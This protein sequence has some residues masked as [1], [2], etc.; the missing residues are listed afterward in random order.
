MFY[1]AKGTIGNDQRSLLMQLG[2]GGAVRPSARPGQS[3][4]RGPGGRSSRK[5]LKFCILRYLDEA[6]NHPV[7]TCTEYKVRRKTHQVQEPVQKGKFAQHVF[8]T[9]GKLKL[10]IDLQISFHAHGS[11]PKRINQRSFLGQLHEIDKKT[12]TKPKRL[13][14]ILVTF[15]LLTISVSY[16][17][18]HH[19]KFLAL[20]GNQLD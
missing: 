9:L 10:Q 17:R 1:R 16:R 11:M 6:K 8:I 2:S 15:A 12:N 4:G 20:H 3:P 19:V 7:Y 14:V 13:P 5:I 18:I